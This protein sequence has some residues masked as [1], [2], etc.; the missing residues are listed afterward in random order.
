[1]TKAAR[2]VAVGL[3]FFLGTCLVGVLGYRVAGWGLVDAS[4]WWSSPSDS[5]RLREGDKVIVLGHSN[6]LPE[7]RRRYE[8][9]TEVFY[10]GARVS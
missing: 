9:K 6:D 8:L 4:T 3:A 7:L 2:H 5:L 1:M 10:R